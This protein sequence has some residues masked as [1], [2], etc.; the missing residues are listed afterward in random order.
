MV[1]GGGVPEMPGALAEGA[2]VEPTIWTGL[3][4]SSPIAREEVFG[5]AP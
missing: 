3:D 4:D 5:P 1:T 2:W